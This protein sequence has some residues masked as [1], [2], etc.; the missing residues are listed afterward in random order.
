VGTHTLGENV[1]FQVLVV[2]SHIDY[3]REECWIY[4]R[5]DP[6][7]KCHGVLGGDVVSYSPVV[8]EL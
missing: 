1:G 5:C 4:K 7:T 3:G 2:R 6:L 8:L